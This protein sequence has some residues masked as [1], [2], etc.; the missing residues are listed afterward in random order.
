M[1]SEESNNKWTDS[2]SDESTF[3][4]SSI[5]SEEEE[6]HCL[7]ADDNDE[8]FDFYNTEFIHEDLVLAL[9]EMIVQLKYII[10]AFGPV[11]QLT[12]GHLTSL[13]Q[14]PPG[15]SNLRMLHNLSVLC[16]T[17]LVFLF[18]QY[19]LFALHLLVLCS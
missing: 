1:V 9:N 4:S 6:V 18:A 3:N 14:L 2:D 5:D 7:M 16:L 12:P 19:F 10:E 17:A 11:Y 13:H 15:C 8:P